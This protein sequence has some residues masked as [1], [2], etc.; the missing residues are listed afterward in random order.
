MVGFN[1]D[2]GGRILA[3]GTLAQTVF[4]GR[5]GRLKKWQ[6]YAHLWCGLFTKRGLCA[7][8]A[9][10]KRRYPPF[11]VCGCW[12]KGLVEA[13][14]GSYIC[15]MQIGDKQYIELEK[16]EELQQAY[17]LLKHRLEQLERLLFGTKSE[18]F[19]ADVPGQLALDLDVTKVEAEVQTQEVAAHRRTKVKPVK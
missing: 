13:V 15:V 8:K 7:K 17:A 18:R 11:W 14:V 12:K 5:Q 10:K 19:V 16:F 4:V 6:R 2:I 3:L 9:E 1:V